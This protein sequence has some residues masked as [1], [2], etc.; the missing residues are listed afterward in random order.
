M[1]IGYQKGKL[2]KVLSARHGEKRRILCQKMSSHIGKKAGNWKLEESP[3]PPRAGCAEAGAPAIT[4]ASA[5]AGV[6]RG[7]EE[8]SSS[9]MCWVFPGLSSS[10]P[11][12]RILLAEVS[13][14]FWRS[15]R[16]FR[17]EELG[18]GNS[19][20]SLNKAPSWISDPT[21]IL[22]FQCQGQN[23]RLGVGWGIWIFQAGK[24][25]LRNG[26]MSISNL[27]DGYENTDSRRVN[28]VTNYIFYI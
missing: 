16:E 27:N 10:S 13:I 6:E 15:G 4:Q 12:G 21:A 11:A 26:Q 7:E 1:Q 17:D 2:A 20:P 3:P 28:W 23:L 8:A 22:S 14:P 25:F 18:T 9:L 24:R 19:W 5:R